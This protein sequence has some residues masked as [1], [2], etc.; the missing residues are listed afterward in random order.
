MSDQNPFPNAKS[1]LSPEKYARLKAEAKAPYKG[2]RNFFYLAFAASG[3]IGALTFLARI[4]AGTNL[5]QDI[6]NLTL[7][8][9]L[10][11]AMIALFTWEN[12]EKNQHRD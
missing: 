6:P 10:V 11:A 7:Q 3:F 4:A 8:L 5:T 9:G 2:L 12:K 1:S